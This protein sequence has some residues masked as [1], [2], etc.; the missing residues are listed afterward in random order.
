MDDRAARVRV[1][2]PLADHAEGFRAMLAGR[3]YAPSSA[4]GQLQVMA[5]LS[6]WLGQQGRPAGG[7]APATVDQFL[8]ARKAAGYRR[9]LSARGIALLLE[10]LETAGLAVAAVSP[11]PQVP[12]DDVLAGFGDYLVAE[13]GLAASTVRNYL[14]AARLLAAQVHLEALTASE[15]TGFVLEQC[16]ER[17]AGSA[18]VLVTGLRSLL[19][20]LHLA[21][22]TPVS[23][24]GAVPS[25]ASK[26]PL[27]EAVG[28]GQASLLL[29]SCDRGT[30]AGRRDYAVLVLLVRLGLRAGEVAVMQLGDIDWRAGQVTI[31]GKGNR[32]DQLPLPADAGQ[33]IAAWLRDGRPGCSCR[34]VFTTLL[35]PLGPLTRKAVSAIVTRA[36]RRAGLA[37]VSAHRLRHGAAT[38][39]LRAG[40]SLPEVGQVLRHASMLNTARYARVDHAGLSAVARPWPGAR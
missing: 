33:A 19:R 8:A 24:A 12:D 37:A 40:A 34:Q 31:R 9:W 30:A 29:G 10:Y 4:A 22:F 39:L 16:R 6:R 14:D 3:G 26:S 38:G 5:H 1:S 36:A 32:L 23:L 18:A 27:P 15:V 2:G 25:A 20:Y 11:D 21:G 13:R 7:L 28:P 17:S 35:A